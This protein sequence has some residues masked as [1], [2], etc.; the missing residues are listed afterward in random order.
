MFSKHAKSWFRNAFDKEKQM[1]S[2]CVR[3]F[4]E[5][6]K[7]LPKK[8]LPKTIVFGLFLAYSHWQCVHLICSLSSAYL[9]EDTNKTSNNNT[10]EEDTTK[11]EEKMNAINWCRIRNWNEDQ[12]ITY[13]HNLRYNIFVHQ[14]TTLIHTEFTHTHTQLYCICQEMHKITHKHTTRIN[15]NARSLLTLT[16]SVSSAATSLYLSLRLAEKRECRSSKP[17]VHSSVHE[18]EQQN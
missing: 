8:V 14:S 13:T 9:D 18:R 6:C 4:W 3:H 7:Y 12:I 17:I 5:Q 1:I 16:V 10:I 11:I 2:S 15:P